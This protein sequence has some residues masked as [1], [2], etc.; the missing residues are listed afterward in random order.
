MIERLIEQASAM[1]LFQEY[2]AIF[3]LKQAGEVS[4]KQI[5]FLSLLKSL[6]HSNFQSDWYLSKLKLLKICQQ[7]QKTLTI[8]S[9]APDIYDLQFATFR[10]RVPLPGAVIVH[11]GLE[12][13]IYAYKGQLD[14][15]SPL[16]RYPLPNIGLDGRVC[17]GRVI[18]ETS[19][20]E[21]MWQSFITSEFNRDFANQKSQAF[22]HDIIKQL[23]NLTQSLNTI[24]PEE[25]L[26]ESGLTLTTLCQLNNYY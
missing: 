1:L 25:D 2:Q 23:I 9:L 12:L 16:Y 15:N 20:P 19:N 11:Y 3:I 17:W 4:I 6:Q 22:P 24:Y 14:I 21:A 7:N 13:Y 5:D 8:C 18:P 10:L 26:V